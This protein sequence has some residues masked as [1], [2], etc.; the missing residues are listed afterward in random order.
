MKRKHEEMLTVSI[1][2]TR[3]VA[4]LLAVLDD[5][6]GGDTQPIEMRVHRVLL[7]L[8]DHA[9]QGVYRIGSWERPWLAQAF[10]DYMLRERLE[11][12]DPYGRDDEHGK[13]WNRRPRAGFFENVPL[14]LDPNTHVVC[15]CGVRLRSDSERA[16][17]FAETGHRDGVIDDDNDGPEE[18]D[19]P[20][21]GNVHNEDGE[22]YCPLCSWMKEED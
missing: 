18:S 2:I 3:T 21:P 1:T 11:P 14:Y 7:Q 15:N 17:H 19:C 8:A 10:G 6:G 9:Q 20:G 4:E 16:A 12:G 22:R 13:R 5:A